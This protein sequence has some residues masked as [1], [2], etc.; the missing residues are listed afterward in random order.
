MEDRQLGSFVRRKKKNLLHSPQISILYFI[1][2][3]FLWKFCVRNCAHVWFRTI[4]FFCSLLFPL[5]FSFISDFFS[6]I[7]FVSSIISNCAFM[8]HLLFNVNT[9]ECV[10]GIRLNPHF[11]FVSL[12]L[13]FRK[14]SVTH[15]R[16]QLCRLNFGNMRKPL[17]GQ[18]VVSCSFSG[19]RKI[20]LSHPM[21]H[22]VVDFGK[23]HQICFSENQITNRLLRHCR[24]WAHNDGIRLVEKSGRDLHVLAGMKH[25][26]THID[27]DLKAPSIS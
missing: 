6:L 5:F 7:F 23:W 3:H 4:S 12:S 17:L 18:N 21:C 19:W 11:Q 25:T 13:N 27:L 16:R 9:F 10:C 1:G 8:T 26:H 22:S 14:P 24:W 2:W 20:G 15:W